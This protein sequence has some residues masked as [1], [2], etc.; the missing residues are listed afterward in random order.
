[1][2]NGRTYESLKT[3]RSPSQ[4]DLGGHSGVA[5]FVFSSSPVHNKEEG[6]TMTTGLQKLTQ[7]NP[8]GRSREFL[9]GGFDRTISPLIQNAIQVL[10]RFQDDLNKEFTDSAYDDMM[11]DPAVCA[12]V[13]ILKSLIL[14]E[15]LRV[16][17]R[18]QNKKDPLYEDSKKY[19]DF[20]DRQIK[21]MNRAI[22]AV[23]WEA[24]EA[25][26]YGSS[27]V[28]IVYEDA[29]E[30]GAPILRLKDLKTRRRGNY[31]IIVD[32]YF[33]VLGAVSQEWGGGSNSVYTGSTQPDPSQ[34]IPREKFMLVIP[35]TKNSDPRGIPILR[36]AWNAYF[37]KSQVYPQYLKFLIQF[38]S[39]S[40]VGYTPENTTEEIEV[41]DDNGITV[42]NS[43]G[44][45]Q[46]ITPEADMLET[47]LGFQSGTVAV[48]KGG[49]KLD[50]I[51]SVGNGEAF[52]AA[53]ELFDRQIA[54][55]I[56]KTHRTLLEAKHSSK[57][58]SESAQDITDVFVANLREVVA[59]AIQREVVYQL[60]KVNFGPDIADQF[61]P[62]VTL[63]SM[64]KQDFAKAADAI[65][66]LWA[67]KY[68]HSSQVQEADAMIGLPERDMDAFLG[69]LQEQ[70]DLNAMDQVERMKLLNPGAGTT[71]PKNEP[72]NNN[73]T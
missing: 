45:V 5:S 34:V 71:P 9:S 1:M 18:I 61:A 16:V 31:G 46:T 23:L 22:Q 36:A 44:S 73:G 3:G 8:A 33:N 19:A 37:L 68:L 30:D 53:F 64:P 14:A 51:Q 50:I 29:V 24:L 10:G 35:Q 21:G 20:A 39:P 63:K 43:D 2:E 67:G 69:E 59:Q 11:K 17:P 54:M 15:P 47:L 13:D 58:D 60:I 12:S 32:K 41:V 4:S 6:S 56:L 55:A 62:E 72:D 49:S 26:Q 7:L 38:A 40:L 42:V 65:G 48:L 28:E 25:L 70:A 27:L 52:A 57:A 66:K